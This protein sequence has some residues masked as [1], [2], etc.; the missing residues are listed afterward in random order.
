[1]MS[2]PRQT[3]TQVVRTRENRVRIRLHRRLKPSD[4]RSWNLML[5]S[6]GTAVPVRTVVDS[7]GLLTAAVEDLQWRLALENLR[8]RRPHRWQKPEMAAWTAEL[9]RL[10]EK[11]R[12]IAE[13]V[14]E[15]LNTL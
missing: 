12:R 5:A 6:A 11:Q 3:P 10:A 1:M 13:I 7:P 8:A 4:P 9:A 2:F 15:A 14:A